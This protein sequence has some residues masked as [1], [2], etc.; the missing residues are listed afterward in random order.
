M[1]PADF[2]DEEDEWYTDRH[3]SGAR[4]VR[5]PRRARDDGYGRRSEFL[6]PE[7]HSYTTGLHRTRSQGHSPAPNVT[8]YNTSRLDNESS[9]HVRTDQ[10]SPAPSPRMSP[11]G[12]PLRV[13]DE[14]GLEDELA[15]LRLEVARNRRSRSR[16]VHYHRDESPHHHHGHEY[17]RWQ[18][19]MANERLKEAEEKL[20]QE[21]REELIKKRLELKYLK[22]Q[23]ER[24]I[25]EAKIKAEEDRLKKEWELKMEKE[26]RKRVERAKEAEEERKRIIAENTYK[27]EKQEREAKE[28][29]QAAVDA[30]N[31]KKAEEDKKAKDERERVIAEYER[32][33]VEDA[34]KA[35]RQRE[36]L[37][38]QL[39]IDE[40]KQKQKEK[41]EWE[42]FL[43]KQRQKEE[44][45]KE[46]KK[47]QERELEDQMRKRLAQ[48]GFQENQIQAMIKPEDQTRVSVHLQQGS[49]PLNP[50]RLTHQPTYVKVHKEHLAVDTLVYYDIPYE[51]DRVGLQSAAPHVSNANLCLVRP[52]L[53]HHPARNGQQRDR[54]SLRTHSPSPKPWLYS[55]PYRRATRSW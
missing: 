28:A 23:H 13:A 55:S 54:N 53:H 6:A 25:E 38:M 44:E 40:E 21:K 41:E 22:D 33:K 17:D 26:E 51:I 46:K 37:I 45:E 52:E 42:R 19:Q 4:H 31:K 9:P 7:S 12:R 27:L 34:D 8:I 1:P 11:R 20:Q 49:T 48:F 36:E 3:V 29:R 30:F 43:Q 50:L 14:W 32:K 47:K 10:R 5:P 18:L 15:E 16:S 2:W 35:K 39:R 24:D